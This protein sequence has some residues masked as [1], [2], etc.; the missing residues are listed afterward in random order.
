MD[1]ESAPPC[2]GR[3]R[4]RA[5]IIL[6]EVFFSEISILMLK[7]THKKNVLLKNLVLVPHTCSQL[8]CGVTPAQTLL[9]LLHVVLLSINAVLSIVRSRCVK[10]N[11]TRFHARPR[12]VQ[13]S[14]LTKT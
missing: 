6:S 3:Q 12:S 13:K 2:E 7:G 8:R 14:V 4:A 9:S 1:F 10:V 5:K 11:C